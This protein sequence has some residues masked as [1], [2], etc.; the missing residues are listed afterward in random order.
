MLVGLVC[1]DG[2]HVNAA[3]EGCVPNKFE[4]AEGYEINAKRTACIPAPGSPVPFP[5]LFMAVCMGLIVAG[6]NMKEESLTKVPTCLIFLISS[7]EI[8]EY[9]LIAA[10]AGVLEQYFAS[11]LAAVAA[12]ML[13]VSN[14][15]FSVYYK[16][17]TMQDKAYKEW[18]RV[19][20]V[21]DCALPIICALVNFK[22]IR[23]V[24]S[25]FFGMDTCLANFDEPRSAVH[26]H[27]KM[28]TYF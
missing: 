5:F 9:F 22:A 6:S 2:F 26:K 16:K 3:G 8:L 1:P 15:A 28:M 4:C 21:T 24:F 12:I 13:V 20:P 18:I 7:M 10:F 19:F 14:I 23:F 17:H 11:L 25:G 27:L